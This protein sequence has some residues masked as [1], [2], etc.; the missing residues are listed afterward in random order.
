[1]VIKSMDHLQNVCKNKFVEWYNKSSYA[2]K[3]PN[4][5]QEIGVDDV[6]V[7]WVCKTLQNYNGKT[8]RRYFNY[9]NSCNRLCATLL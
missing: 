8:C 2:N 9:T 6:F 3:G 4:D 7:V 5:I 1:M